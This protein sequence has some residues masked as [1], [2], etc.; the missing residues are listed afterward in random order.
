MHVYDGQFSISFKMEEAQCA[1]QGIRKP[2][3]FTYMY[4]HVCSK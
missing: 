3:K 2:F 1:N 4:V